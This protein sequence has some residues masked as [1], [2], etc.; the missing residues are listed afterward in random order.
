MGKRD[1]ITNEMFYKFAKK[2]KDKGAKI[3]GGCCN[4]NPGHIKSISSLK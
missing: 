2:I 3:L 1:E 4:I